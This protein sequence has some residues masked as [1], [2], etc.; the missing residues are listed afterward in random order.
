MALKW[1]YLK[2]SL[3]QVSQNSRSFHTSTV[4]LLVKAV[5]LDVPQLYIGELTPYENDAYTASVSNLNG[6]I[7]SYMQY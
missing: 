4:Q 3:K 7:P 5:L 1:N 6:I 2:R